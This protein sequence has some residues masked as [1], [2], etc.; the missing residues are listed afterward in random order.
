M[1]CRFFQKLYFIEHQQTANLRNIMCIHGRLFCCNQNA[2]GANRNF[3][4]Q[5]YFLGIRADRYTF[6][7][8]HMKKGPV[9]NFGVFS[10]R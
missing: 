1:F 6:H 10:P 3:L 9:K 2:R 5:G 4:G 8:Y 7:L